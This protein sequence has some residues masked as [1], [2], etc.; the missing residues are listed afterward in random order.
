MPTFPVSRRAYLLACS[1]ASGA[2]WTRS[3][4]S[5]RSADD[6]GR[7]ARFAT[8]QDD[9]TAVLTVSSGE[10]YTVGSGSSETFDR[11]EIMGKLGIDGELVLTGQE[12]EEG[13]TLRIESG[14]THS[15]PAGTAETYQRIVVEGTLS[16]DGTLSATG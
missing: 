11:G 3:G 16:V 7:P 2:A 9:E 4:D 15:I 13:D 6:D 5:H 14:D 8:A 12:D 10:T 1:V